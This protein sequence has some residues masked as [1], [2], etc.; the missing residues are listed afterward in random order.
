[1]NARYSA[2]SFT[3]VEQINDTLPLS[4]GLSGG[5]GTGKTYTALSMARGIAREITDDPSARIGVV[6]TENRRALHYKS[7]FPEMLH[8][9]MQAVDD[10]GEM[11]GFPPE[12]WIEVIDA[13]E[14][15][16][17]TVLV[18][19]SFSHAWEGVN[20]VLDL[21]SQELERLTGG[22]EGKK[23]KLGQL[24]W[25][26][27]KPRYRRLIDRIVRAKMPVIICTRAKPVMQEK[28][29]KTNWKEQNARPTKTRRKDVPWDPAADG[30]LLFEMTAMVILD[31]S[32]PG[33]PIHQIKV[34]DQ[35]KNLLDPAAPMGE[36][37]GQAMASWAKGVDE[38][39]RRK[40]IMDEA[41]AQARNGKEAFVAWWNQPATKE[42]RPIL[43]VIQTELGEIAA[44]ADA[45][46]EA[47]DS[48]DPFATP[49]VEDGSALTDEQI[50]ERDAAFA[51]MQRQ[52]NTEPRT[53]G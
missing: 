46:R 45:D 26:S 28:S 30:D 41:R 44:K 24:A 32:A 23:N 6:D 8:F 43:R 34:A 39:A 7:V 2:V 18:I 51:E 38:G 3:P 5:S 25:A 29:A 27:V 36:G 13:A 33:H 40:A 11:I 42:S 17:I 22:D 19:D 10:S 52:Q 1:M 48:D 49:P 12:R 37:T 16:E 14:A 20:G 50:A 15:A 53:D 4:I 35:F 9:D 47:M 31:P 21:Q